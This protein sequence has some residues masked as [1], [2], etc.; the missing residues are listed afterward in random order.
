MHRRVDTL[1]WLLLAV[2]VS[3]LLTMVSVPLTDTTEARYGEIARIMAET[4]DF[5]TPWFDYGVP[6]WGKPPLSFW[7]E[8]IAFKLFG[9]NEIAVRLPSW[10]ANGATLTLLYALIARLGSR[11]QALIGA[12]IYAS[13]ALSYMMSGAVLTDPFLALGTTLALVGFILGLKQPG[14]LWGW[15]FFV[16]LAIGLLAKGPLVLVLV[17]GPLFLWLL[18]RRRWRDLLSLPWLRGT[19]LTALLTLPWYIAAELKTPGFVDYFIVGEHIRRFLD[20]GWQ[21]DR[22]GS[23]H[24]HAYGTIWLY[25][26]VATLPWGLVA[27]YHLLRYWITRRASGLRALNDWQRLLLLASIFPSLF[28]TLSGNILWTYQLPALAPLAA[29]LALCLFL[30]QDD[31]AGECLTPGVLTGVLVIPLLL[32]AA[33]FY[34]QFHPDSLKSEKSLVAYYEAHKKAT[35]PALLYLDKPPF[36]ARYY[37]HGRVVTMPLNKLQALIARTPA[38]TFYCAVPRDRLDKVTAMLP[39]TTAIVFRNRRFVLLRI[40]P[41]AGT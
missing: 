23:A 22:Y 15:S 26:L 39:G 30:R 40:T 10:L 7:T 32:V 31:A 9:V 29:L 4:G 21:G 1:L 16:G 17:G 35:T 13:M 19:L 36:S 24:Q 38:S 37:S 20:S 6:F 34:L 12:L 11:R 5:I 27:L 18:W 25:W 3:R 8:A 28:F 33:G 2:I 41:D 14:S